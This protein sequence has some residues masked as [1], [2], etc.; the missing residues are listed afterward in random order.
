MENGGT[1]LSMNKNNRQTTEASLDGYSDSLIS[2]SLLTSPSGRNNGV[3]FNHKD[4]NNFF[5]G[6]IE[7]RW[8]MTW[9]SES[10]FLCDGYARFGVLVVLDS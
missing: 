2:R 3:D 7:R 9:Q 6:R 4:W 5:L 10:V 1:N 8:A